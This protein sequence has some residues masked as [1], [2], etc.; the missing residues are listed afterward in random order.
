MTTALLL[1]IYL[2]F[3]SLGLP[4]TMLGAGWPAMRSDLGVGLDMAGAVSLVI[5][6]GTMVSSLLSSRLLHRFG[7]GKVAFFS[8]LLTALSLLGFSCSHRFFWLLLPAVPLGL[9]AGA[10]DAGL[11]NFVALH[12]KPCHMNFLH[13]FWGLGAMSGP[14]IM[15]FWLAQGESWRMGYRTVAFL[16]FGL[17]LILGVSLPLW[18]R[19]EIVVQSSEKEREKPMG[20]LFALKLPGVRTS[21]IA[22]FCYCSL[23]ISTGLWA[24]SFLAEQ[25]GVPAEDA[26]LCTSLFYGGIAAG[27]FLSGLLSE[28]LSGRLLTRIGQGLCGVGAVF[29][30]LPFPLPV[31]VTGL[32]LFGLGCAPLYPAMLRETPVR[33][34]RSASQTVMG[35][36]MAIQYF[37]ST[38]MPPLLGFLA[39]RTSISIFPWFLLL[40]IG[41]MTV[42]CE[43]LNTF[44]SGKN[45]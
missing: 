3:V 40:T 17:V 22:L 31:T 32:T 18:K 14:V 39:V 24:S 7:T 20:N 11:N 4:D 41:L 44:F 36:Q 16:Q 27:R 8:V 23:E 29:L 33:F 10:V 37:G 30:L 25:R 15:S 43:R 2:A 38:V 35:L 19:Q 26:A 28:K 21:L 9:G 42:F 34:G 12:Y 6:L 13:C 5:S 1:V 45:S